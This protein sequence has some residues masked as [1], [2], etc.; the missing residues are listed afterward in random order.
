MLEQQQQQQYWTSSA[1]VPGCLA[2]VKLDEAPRKRK[3]ESK[4]SSPPPTSA[5][6]FARLDHR[7]THVLVC[8]PPHTHTRTHAKR[9]HHAT[10]DERITC[11]DVTVC[12]SFLSFTCACAAMTLFLPPPV[13]RRERARLRSN[14]RRDTRILLASCRRWGE[15]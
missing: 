6:T 14:T 7:A 3:R 5:L 8:S 11:E 1:C 13:V 2:S 15:P 12:F 4:P 10:A 9:H